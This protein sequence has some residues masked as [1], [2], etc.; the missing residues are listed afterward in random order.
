MYIYTPTHTYIYIYIYIVS[1]GK[2]CRF[3]NARACEHRWTIR[4]PQDLPHHP[5]L[6]K[7]MNSRSHDLQLCVLVYTCVRNT[8]MHNT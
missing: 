8:C 6:C 5:N 3:G 4:T 2:A 7:I 1:S